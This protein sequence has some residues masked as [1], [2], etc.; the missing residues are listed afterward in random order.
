VTRAPVPVAVFSDFACPFSYV[1]EAALA[2]MEAAG[3]ARVT[4]LAFELHPVP[5]PLPAEDDGA[6]RAALAPLAAEL[7]LGLAEAPPVPART[8]KAHE[9][10][11]FAAAHGV[12]P[13][14]RAAVFRARFA[15]GRDV[16]RVDVLVELGA[17]LGLDAT[18]LK[19]VLDVDSFAARV[20]GERA[21]AVDA[22]VEG[23]PTLVAGEGDD[24]RWWSGARP[25]AELR[26]WVLDDD[27][28]AGP[29][30]PLPDQES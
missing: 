9:A 12:G 8:A 11:A 16:G 17:A 18:E 5:A 30:A 25:F 4:P 29:D 26:R 27:E 21:A 23:V 3:E 14:F 19:V 22:G 13:A 1:T 10:A 6:W 28:S 2:R 15:E 20:A 24:A 7:G